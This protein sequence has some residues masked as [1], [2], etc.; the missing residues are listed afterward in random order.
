[1]EIP[2]KD[3]QILREL[4]EKKAE[5]GSLLIQKQ[6]MEMWTKLNKLEKT[7]PMVWLNEV[8]WHEMN[9]NEELTIKT[10]NQ[11]CQ[12]IEG[13]LRREIYQWNHM[14]CDM[15]VEPD[16][17]SGLAISDTG[18]GISEDVDIVRTDPNSGVVSRHFNIQ[19]SSE[20]DIEK[21]KDPVITHDEEKSEEYF[22]T[23]KNIFE[24]IM[25]VQKIGSPGFWFA[26][27]D[28]LIRLTGVQDG[29]LDL[30]LRPDYIHKLLNRTIEAYLS[31]LDQYEKLNLL[32][33][34]NNNTRIGSGGYGYTDELPSSDYDPSYVHLKDIWGCGTAQIFSEVSPAMHEEFALQYER[35]WM[36]R[37]GMNYYGC[38]EP[39]HNKMDILKSI[40]NLCKISMG[41]TVD[42]EKA[43]EN[44][45]NNYVLSIKPNPAILAESKWHPERARAEL[46]KSLNKAKGCSVEVILKDISTVNHE[47]KRLWEWATIASEVTESFA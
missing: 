17:Y 31:R 43:I 39:L 1:M 21:I 46:E 41:P 4:G 9:V 32:A 20:D 28:E 34:N 35:R 24:G 47:P 23:L 40:H 36:E 30:A 37:F 45:A 15:V 6:R 16:M 25:P 11:F 14:Q 42:I 2:E 26:P 10:E 19:I 13:G 22:Q 18:F 27:W 7:K 8:S 5:I 33:L 12:H 29:L 3:K 38:C 44:G